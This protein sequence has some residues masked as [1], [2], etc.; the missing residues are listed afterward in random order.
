MIG[1]EYDTY[2]RFTMGHIPLRQRMTLTTKMNCSR[3]YHNDS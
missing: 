2:D 3:L 1:C